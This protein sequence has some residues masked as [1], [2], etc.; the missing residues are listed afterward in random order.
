MAVLA[1]LFAASSLMVLSDKAAADGL[2]AASQRQLLVAGAERVAGGARQTSTPLPLRQGIF[3]LPFA[4]NQPAGSFRNGAVRFQAVDSAFL[5][6][7]DPGTLITGP[8]DCCAHFAEN[9]GAKL[10]SGKT[11]IALP[12]TVF[13]GVSGSREAVGFSVAA[14]GEPL[15]EGEVLNRR[16]EGTQSGPVI[17]PMKEGVGFALWSDFFHEPGE[18]DASVWGAPIAA[19]G[20]TSGPGILIESTD[21]GAQVPIDGVQMADGRL[22]V[23]WR[24]AGTSDI[25][26]RNL[27]YARFLRSNGERKGRPFLIAANNDNVFGAQLRL[28]ALPDGNFVV[29]WIDDRS[30]EPIPF[31]R[32]FSPSG[33]M[34]TWPQRVGPFRAQGG[35]LDVAALADSRFVIAGT[36]TEAESVLAAQL[37]SPAGERIGERFVLQTLRRPDAVP[38]LHVANAGYLLGQAPGPGGLATAT[39]PTRVFILWRATRSHGTYDLY[40]RALRAVATP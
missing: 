35:W 21:T 12:L 34:V 13:E 23:V 3:I 31:Y 33:E 8:E 37:F 10:A 38:E 11:Q 39:D 24:A 6:S 28:A 2:T 18:S 7:G 32:I 14:S 9:G 1:A 17:I 29:V 15:S 19:D 20:S 36:F 22:L 40:G 27:F 16:T 26:G 5:K 30:G 25:S 4:T